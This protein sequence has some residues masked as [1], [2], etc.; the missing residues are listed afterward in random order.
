MSCPQSHETLK[1]LSI[2][3]NAY[4]MFRVLCIFC[5]KYYNLFDICE[6]RNGGSS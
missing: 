5:I 1:G 3:Q 4:I 6:K 2:F